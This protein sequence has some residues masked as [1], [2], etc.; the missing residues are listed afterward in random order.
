MLLLPVVNEA[1]DERPTTM[2]SAPLMTDELPLSPAS[3]PVFRVTHI[4]FWL[5]HPGYKYIVRPG[6]ETV[7]RIRARNDPRGKQNQSRPLRKDPTQTLFWH[8]ADDLDIH[9]APMATLLDDVAGVLAKL[10][11]PTATLLFPHSRVTKGKTKKRHTIS[12]AWTRNNTP[13]KLH[14]YTVYFCYPIHFDWRHT[15]ATRCWLCHWPL[16]R[17]HPR[18]L[19]W[20]QHLNPA[21]WIRRLNL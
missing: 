14:I 19:N 1:P 15:Q 21:Q 9:M 12:I 11:A 8:D 13:K 4:I 6:R 3:L 16:G 5:F 20:C 17:L 18:R 2:L 10:E 7:S